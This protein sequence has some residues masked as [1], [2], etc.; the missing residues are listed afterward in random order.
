MDWT[1]RLNLSLEYIE[2][3]LDKTIKLSKASETACCSAYHY[4][5]IFSLIAGISLGEYIRNRRLTL[6][7][8]DLQNSMG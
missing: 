6:A 1:D 7:G 8:Y 2:D 4:Q 5:R 3:N